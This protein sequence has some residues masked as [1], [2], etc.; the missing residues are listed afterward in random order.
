MITGSTGLLG[1]YLM[2]RAANLGVAI[3]IS[4]HTDPAVDLRVIEQVRKTMA[5]TR[6]D[7][8]VHAAG[9]TDVDACQRDPAAA[10]RANRATTECLA[11]SLPPETQF[12][13][14]STDQVYPDTAGPHIEESASPANIYGASKLAGEGAALLHPRGLALRTNMFGPSRTAG[15][16][17]LSDVFAEG[18]AAHRPM[19]LFTDLKFSP[20]H[21][22]TLADLLFE[23]VD[24]T[25][26]GVL[27]LGCRAGMTKRDFGLA[28]A[29]HLALNSETAQ[30]SVS[31]A[32]PGRAP[33]A[34][35]LRLDVSRVEAL[36]G[37]PMPTLSEEIARL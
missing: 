28:V 30:D 36:L 13:Y 10:D 2:E 25:A 14:V 7:V 11:I 16:K 3:G 24:H 34:K 8:V 37:R 6:P 15:R 12:V 19:R 9:L 4:R 32:I 23:L 35:D 33:R 17:S 27:N 31:D 18:F 20:L 29:D 26:T 22:A 1:P 21:M 5:A